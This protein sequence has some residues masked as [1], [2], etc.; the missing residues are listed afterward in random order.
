MIQKPC[1]IRSGL[2]L[3]EHLVVGL[4][5]TFFFLELLVELSLNEVNLA[6]VRR[7][8]SAKVIPDIFQNPPIRSE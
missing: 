5:L 8:R 2:F 3:M 4:F 1:L 7:N 6:Y